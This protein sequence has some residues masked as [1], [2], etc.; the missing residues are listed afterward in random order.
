MNPFIN[1]SEDTVQHPL[2]PDGWSLFS[3]AGYIETAGPIFHRLEP[4]G[5]VNGS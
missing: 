5:S 2:V 3:N 4:Q 1:E